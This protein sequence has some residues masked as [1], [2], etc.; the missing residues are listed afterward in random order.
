[1]SETI[2]AQEKYCNLNA[3]TIKEEII[4][5]LH[6]GSGCD[7]ARTTSRGLARAADTAGLPE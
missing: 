1:M 6:N 4:P 3:L 7:T 2:H 5:K